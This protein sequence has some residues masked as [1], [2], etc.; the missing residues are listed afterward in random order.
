MRNTALEKSSDSS[1]N[2]KQP[3][4]NSFHRRTNHS[5][6][7]V[8]FDNLAVRCPPHTTERALMRKIDCRL[9]PMLCL[10]YLMAFLDR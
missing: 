9:L 8:E 1:S 6:D 5:P 10:L 2:P 4:D 7:D 3:Y